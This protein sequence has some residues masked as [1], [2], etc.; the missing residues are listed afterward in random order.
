MKK[1]KKLPMNSPI[2]YG[3]TI[4]GAVFSICNEEDMPW[5]YSNF[6]QVKYSVDMGMYVFEDQLRLYLICPYLRT[7][8]VSF[9]DRYSQN[10]SFVD[11]LIKFIDCDYYLYIFLDWY[12]L[13]PEKSH[14]AHST[15]VSG[16]DM[17]KGVFLL[18]D[19]YDDGKFITIEQ[20][21][22]TVEKAFYSAWTATVGNKIDNDNSK[23]FDYLKT[24]IGMKYRNSV[25]TTFDKSNFLTQ[26]EQ[27]KE[28]VPFQLYDQEETCYYGFDSYN[29]IFE[30]FDKT[31]PNIRIGKRDFHLLCEQKLMMKKRV[32]Y[33][34]NHHYIEGQQILELA[35]DIYQDF[36]KLRSKFIKYSFCAGEKRQV[37]AERI[38]EK[39]RMSIEKEKVLVDMLLEALS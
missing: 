33:L 28:S 19:N 14:M 23:D 2:I 20:S 1:V 10:H 25:S 31:N 29:A 7:D 4:L 34:L 3:Y 8:Y 15:L 17:E 21:F 24:L 13:Y 12:Y 16:Y 26:L 38:K 30:F 5:F 35:C 32:E 27:Y 39:L 37:E 6:V 36:M 22:E 9:D 11:T 18:S